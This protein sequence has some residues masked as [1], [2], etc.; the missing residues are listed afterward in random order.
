MVDLIQHL[1]VFNDRLRDRILII[2]PAHSPSLNM[3]DLSTPRFETYTREQKE[4]IQNEIVGL[5]NYVFASEDYKLTGQ[6][7]YRLRLCRP[8]YPLPTQFD[9]T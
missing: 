6:M 7:G 1:A 3:F 5:F 9:D 2:D 4:D 8:P